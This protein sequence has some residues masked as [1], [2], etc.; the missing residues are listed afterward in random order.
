MKTYSVVYF[1]AALVAIVL[2][3]IFSRIAKAMGLLDLPGARKVHRAPVPRVGGI[4]FVVS[5]LALV[6]PVLFLDNAIGE[7]FRKV[8][9]QV[10]VLLAGGAFMF[11]VGLI[12]DLRGLRA[13][14][15]LLAQTIAAITVCAFGVRI[16]EIGVF[17][18]FT[19]DFGWLAWPVTVVWILSITNAINIIDG[20]DGLAAGIAAVTCAVIA[21]FAFYSG[22]CVMVALMLA[23]LGGLTGFLFFNFNPA[24]IFM[25]DSGTLFVGFLIATA[26]VLCVEKSA[27][28]VGLAMPALALGL[29]I[30]DTL[31]SI[32]RRV[33]GRRSIFAPDSNHI[34]HRLLKMGLGHRHAVIILYGVTLTVA[35]LGML[36]MVARDKSAFVLLV[37]VALALLAIFRVAG[38]V[39]LRESLTTLRQNLAIAR[40]VRGEKICFENAQLRMR[41]ANSFHEW[42]KAVCTMAEEMDFEWLALI[43]GDDKGTMRASVWH[44]SSTRETAP[45]RLVTLTLPLGLGGN[46]LL[47]ARA[48]LRVDGSLESA[49]RRAALF[50]RLMD[51]H[52]MA[53]VATPPMSI[54]AVLDTPLFGPLLPHRTNGRII[55]AAL[56]EAEPTTAALGNEPTDCPSQPQ[57]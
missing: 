8:R 1:G 45:A 46:G 47:W 18:W 14:T 9:T 20:L 36:L 32:L 16:E 6:I 5:V 51:E 53:S 41:E 42:W 19:L 7:A 33:L 30:F 28:L 13:R 54:T 25:G 37:G 3:P 44:R 52:G 40:E 26:S 31:F 55:L 10:I 43:H 22:Q 35:G 2:T 24:K 39:R 29:P 50:G 57:G 12:D 38:A 17:G 56:G 15:K 11:L 21:V 49:G 48:A 34:H 27:T 4:V 23:M